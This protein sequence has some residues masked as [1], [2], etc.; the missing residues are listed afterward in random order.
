[1]G[2]LLSD[3]FTHWLNQKS[4]IFLIDETDTYVSDIDKRPT[5]TNREPSLENATD[6]YEVSAIEY[7]LK[8]KKAPGADLMTKEQ[9]KYAGAILC[10]HDVS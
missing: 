6:P 5:N 8:L 7:E 10:R 3:L 1:M 9:I 4:M 2:G